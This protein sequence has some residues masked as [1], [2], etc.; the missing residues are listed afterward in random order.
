MTYNRRFFL[1]RLR[2]NVILIKKEK[3]W[4][5][6]IIVKK[7]SVETNEEL[8]KFEKKIECVLFEERCRR[9]HWFLG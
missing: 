5:Q 8:V 6:I 1:F 9:R 4:K 7:K 2:V 3:N